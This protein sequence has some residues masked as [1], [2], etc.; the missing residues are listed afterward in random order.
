MQRILPILLLLLSLMLACQPRR[1]ASEGKTSREARYLIASAEDFAPEDLQAIDESRLASD[2]HYQR[3]TAWALW[4][5]LNGSVVRERAEFV[6]WQTWYSKE[7]LQRIFHHLYEGLSKE[8]RRARA[9]FTPAQIEAGFVFH[10]KEQFLS[11]AWKQDSFE[12]WFAKYDSDAKKSSLPGMNKVLMNKTALVFF[13][14]NYA[15]IDR[16]MKALDSPCP[17]L[18]VPAYAAFLKTAWRRGQD[19]FLLP[20]YQTDRLAEQ[21]AAPEWQSQF[22]K[23]P[24]EGTS[25]RIETA[26]GQLFHLAG[27]HLSLKL[28]SSWFWTSL[29][30]DQKAERD[31]AIKAAGLAPLWEHY[32]LCSINGF[33]GL[34]KSDSSS[35]FESAIARNEQRLGASWCSNP[36]LE[37]GPNNQQTNCIGCHQHA[38]SPWTDADFQDHLQNHL[39]LLTQKPSTPSPMVS[40]SDL[41]WSLF[42]GPEPFA[43]F[44]TQEVDYFDVYDLY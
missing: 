14:K 27:V 8:E 29:W 18:E 38:G 43:S 25:Y 1:D 34:A 16:C 17:A 36:Y 23:I 2:W 31:P 30:L 24:E 10:D 21:F 22:A 20:Y 42:N 40:T 5:D 11:P 6:K 13:L 19:D 12:S 33:H 41:V 35:A 44:I 32:R 26:S 7:D 37:G 28:R 15:A 3:E 4:S 39:A 9:S